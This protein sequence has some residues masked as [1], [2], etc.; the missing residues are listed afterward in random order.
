MG[1]FKL[2]DTMIKDGLS[3][4]L[5]R[6]PHGQHGR[7]RRAPVADH[8][9]RAGPLRASARR[10]RPRPRRRP[11][12]SRTRSCPSRSRPAR[13]TSSSTNDEYIRYGATLE[14]MQK[15]K[16]AFDKEGTVTAANASGINDG[17][18]AVVL[19]TEDE[20][21]RRGHHP[22]GAHRVVGD[23]RRRSA[24]HGHRARSPP[25]A[26]RWKRPAGRSTT[27]SWSR[28]TRPSPR[29][30]ARSTRNS[31]GTRTSSTSMA[32]P[33]PSATRS[34]RRAR[35]SSTRWSIEMKRRGAK[36]GLATLCI[37]GGMGVAMCVE[38]MN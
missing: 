32:A 36:K 17:A 8:P 31:A 26:R 30:P 7:E 25:R 9:R 38:A 21:A 22:A 37:G 20:A 15:L 11:A 5:Q 23:G 34:A 29:R 19:M 33:S 3:G 6:L 16:P 13:A 2:I 35:A 4:R 28:P 27:S 12:G 18:G 14:A 24:D 1:D 10:T